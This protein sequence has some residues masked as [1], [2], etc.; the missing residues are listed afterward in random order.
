MALLLGTDLSGCDLWGSSFLGAD[1]RGAD[2]CG[3][4]LR[5]SAFLTPIQLGAARGD[6]ETLLP[7]FLSRPTSWGRS[8]GSQ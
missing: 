1:L 2:L 4:D 3:A 7:P 5:G 6:E 8:S